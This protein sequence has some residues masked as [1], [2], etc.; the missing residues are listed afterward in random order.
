MKRLFLAWMPTLL[1]SHDMWIDKTP[2]YTFYYG[3]LIPKQGESKTLKHNPNY[4][5]K[6][7]CLTKNPIRSDLKTCDIY[8]VIYH[9]G[10]WTKTPFGTKNLPKTEVKYPLK[11]WESRDTITYIER[12]VPTHPLKNELTLLPIAPFHHLKKGDKITLEVRYQGHPIPNVPVA[13]FGHTRGLSDEQGHIN[14][15]LRTEGLQQLTATYTAPLKS[16]KADHRVLNATL[17][18][19]IP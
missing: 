1:F 12:Y 16:P 6:A 17:N 2:H 18:F 19:R 3:H 13:Y 10:Y 8:T 15:R 14:I 7:I 5:S 11:S 4:L 9:S